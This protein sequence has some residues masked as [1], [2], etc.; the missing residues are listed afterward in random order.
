M[1][2]SEG[3]LSAPV[4]AFGWAAAAAGVSVGLKKTAASRLPETALVSSVLFLAS[5]VH[6]PLGPSSI[7]LTMLGLAG[8]LLGW[9][10]VPA[11][12]IALLLQGMLFQ[13]GGLLSLGVNTTVMGSAALSAFGVWRLFPQAK[14]PRP[15][16]MRA[17]GT[18][19]AAGFAC[20]FV[21][22]ITG[23]VLVTLSLFLSSGDLAS[24]G[25]LIFAANIPLAVVE[26]VLSSFCVFFLQRLLPQYVS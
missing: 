20:G 22:V 7:H 13:F 3:V 25:A 16:R 17:A 12:F 14:D 2:I 9:S 24:T 6:V 10:A 8:I 5:L 19:S 18:K 1:H 23:S 26:G 4:I 11:L 15:G 21:A